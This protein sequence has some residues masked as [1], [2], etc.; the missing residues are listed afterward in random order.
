MS[1]VVPGASSSLVSAVDYR[2][3]S[4]DTAT[5]DDRLELLLSQATATIQRAT[6]QT[7][8]LVRDDTRTLRS[9]GRSLLLPE[10]PIVSVTAVAGYAP[11]DWFIRGNALVLGRPD[12]GDRYAVNGPSTDES[13]RF[14]VGRWSEL[15][16]VTYTHGYAVAPADLQ[17]LCVG[18]VARALANPGG[19]DRGAIDDY[20]FGF[21]APIAGIGLTPTEHA[22]VRRTYGRPNG[23]MVVR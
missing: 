2:I 19:V 4:G 5:A 12:Y 9:D 11:G 18:M 17:G 20:Q 23:S 7:L 16:T 22:W 21:S 6:R 8:T 1:L 13:F 3:A 10:R 14:N 15:V